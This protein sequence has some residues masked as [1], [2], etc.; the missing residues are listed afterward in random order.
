MEPTTR[1]RHSHHPSD[2]L[3]HN[4]VDDAEDAMETLMDAC[5]F[6]I[7]DC[8]VYATDSE[9]EMAMTRRTITVLEEYRR[10]ADYARAIF[11]G[12]REK[13]P[14]SDED[15]W[16]ERTAAIL[17][18]RAHMHQSDRDFSNS[19]AQI[20]DAFESQDWPSLAI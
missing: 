7:A 16:Y 3:Y 2:R 17:H 11:I 20:A 4:E 8:H 10:A 18:R 14:D 15:E 9:E 13:H 5:D 6:E 12:V 19:L 1:H